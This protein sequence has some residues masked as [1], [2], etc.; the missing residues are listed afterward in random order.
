MLYIT[1]EMAKDFDENC[2]WNPSPDSLIGTLEQCQDAL[3]MAG[4]TLEI[5][6]VNNLAP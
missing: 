6:K 3:V 2:L 4:Y 5:K 1:K